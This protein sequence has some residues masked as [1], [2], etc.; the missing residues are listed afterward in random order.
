M[1]DIENIENEILNLSDENKEVQEELKEE[2]DVKPKRTKK[3]KD[4][5]VVNEPIVDPVL[6]YYSTV[7]DDVE[8]EYNIVSSFDDSYCLSTGLLTLDL[9]MNGGIRDGWITSLG[10]EGTGKSSLAVKMM[11]SLVKSGTTGYFVDAESALDIDNACK[12]AGINDITDY[13]G[14]RAYNGKGWEKPPKIKYCSENTLETVFLCINKALSKL[15]D[16]LYRQ[17][18]K[19][20]YYVFSREKESMEVMKSLNLKHVPALYTQTGR[21]WCEAPDGKFQIVFIIDS[22]PA[23][24]P[25]AS[26]KDDGDLNGQMGI[27]QKA[28][29]KCVPLVR[30]LL[31][32]KHSVILAINQLKDAIGKMYG[33]AEFE[34][35]GN[36]VKYASDVRN[37][38]SNMSV[39]DFFEKGKLPSGSPTSKYGE[40]PS[41]EGDGVDM[42]EYK[43]ITNIKNKRGVAYRQGSLRFWTSSIDGTVRGIDYVYDALMYL[44]QTKQIELRKKG[45]R[46]E[47]VGFDKFANLPE[48]CNVI[49]YQDFKQLLVGQQRGLDNLVKDFCDKYKVEGNIVN[50]IEKC[51][52]QI[53]SRDAFKM[54]LTTSTTSESDDEGEAQTLDT[55]NEFN[56]FS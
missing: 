28:Y 44:E 29:S 37:K 4:K 32:K 17:E 43:K 3:E 21:Y 49:Q 15:P 22:L 25:D 35:C 40:E 30:G 27:L 53:E 7:L 34:P 14:L 55:E 54:L 8:K 47:I 9:I 10:Y 46:R 48:S 39:P 41:V 23:L 50:I 11:G 51:F 18:T 42:Y 16:K 6:N 56:D 31:R 12:I 52:T 24:V 19:K 33:P 5:S 45:G 36:A 2:Q 38:L 1:E 20:W 26:L 13:F